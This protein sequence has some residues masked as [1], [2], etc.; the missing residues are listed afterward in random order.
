M[1][2]FC[3]HL[4]MKL[5]QRIARSSQYSTHSTVQYDVWPAHHSTNHRPSIPLLLP[6]RAGRPAGSELYGLRPLW[7][8]PKPHIQLEYC[9][10]CIQIFK[11]VCMYV[12]CST[13]LYL[14]PLRFHCIGGCWDRTQDICDFGIGCHSAN[15]HPNLATSHSQLGYISSNI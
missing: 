8:E 9:T 15:S 11:N 5:Q 14:P 1:S 10:V 3:V 6:G 12:L 4:G 2:V 7:S 13:L